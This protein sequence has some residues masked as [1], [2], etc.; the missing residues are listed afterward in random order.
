MQRL[1]IPWGHRSEREVEND[2]RVVLG[3]DDRDDTTYV[4]LP[5]PLGHELHAVDGQV[6]DEISL[7]CQ[8]RRQRREEGD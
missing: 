7:L 4:L 6:A 3:P 1:D 8:A 5:G 2:M